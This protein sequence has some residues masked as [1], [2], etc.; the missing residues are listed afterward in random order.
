MKIVKVVVT[1][2]DNCDSGTTRSEALSATQCCLV[3]TTPL[4]NSSS[5]VGWRPY[6]DLWQQGRKLYSSWEPVGDHS[7]PAKRS[8]VDEPV[9][10][11]TIPNGGIPVSE[12]VVL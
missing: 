3:D 11:F 1:A 12:D 8:R 2:N 4:A 5:K 7:A 9:L 10:T 6:L